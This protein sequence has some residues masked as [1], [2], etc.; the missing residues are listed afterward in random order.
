MEVIE[1]LHG[2]HALVFYWFQH[3]RDRILQAL[4]KSGLRVRVYHGAEDENVW[5]A[6]QVDVLLAQPMSCGYGL[7]LQRGGHHAIWYTLPNWA[8]EIY[9]Q[10][11]CRLYRQGQTKPVISHIL[12]VQGGMDVD[13]MAALEGKTDVQDSLLAALKARIRRYQAVG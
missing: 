10:S 9:Q 5:N 2:E 12:L 4:S 7:N 11:N 3:E 8:L 13:V 1:Q 6:G